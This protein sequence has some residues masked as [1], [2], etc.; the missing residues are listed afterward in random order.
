[1]IAQVIP[2]AILA[3]VVLVVGAWT[4]QRIVADNSDRLLAGALQT[5]R[6]TASVEH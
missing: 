6:A 2:L 4:A 3:I 5:I 1:M